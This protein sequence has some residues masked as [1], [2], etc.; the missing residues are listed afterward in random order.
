M[1]NT[2]IMQDITIVCKDCG[3][4]FVWTV[5]EQKFFKEK[6]LENRPVRCKD[7]RNKKRTKFENNSNESNS[8]N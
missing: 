3:Q 5:G 7:C 6:G 4:E 8:N 1:E 2:E